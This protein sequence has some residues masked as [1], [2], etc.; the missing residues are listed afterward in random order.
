MGGMKAFL[1]LLLQLQLKDQADSALRFTT[2]NSKKE[3]ESTVL[4]SLIW[5]IGS[6]HNVCELYRTL[7]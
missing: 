5:E 4:N 2:E 1:Y 7:H 3:R 6:S